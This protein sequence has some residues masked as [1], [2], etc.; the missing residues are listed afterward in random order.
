MSRPKSL[1]KTEHLDDVEA[2]IADYL[3]SVCMI[4][5]C[6]PLLH[7]EDAK[8]IIKRLGDKGYIISKK[9]GEN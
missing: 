8:A 5:G 1:L 2:I 7:K 9:D 6:L 3:E 4:P